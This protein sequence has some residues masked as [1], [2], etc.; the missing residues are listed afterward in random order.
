MITS[1]LAF[2][3]INRQTTIP[4]R[5]IKETIISRQIINDDQ[6]SGY[7]Y[8]MVGGIVTLVKTMNINK[9]M[10]YAEQQAR[11]VSAKKWGIASIVIGIVLFFKRERSVVFFYIFLT[12]LNSNFET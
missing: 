10:T 7:G 12:S 3:K 2:I 1:Q 6:S 8:N 4:I 9:A 5:H 11:Y